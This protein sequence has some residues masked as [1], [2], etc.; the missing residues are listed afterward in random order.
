MH[1]N[2]TNQSG[3]IR[4]GVTEE[5]N[6]D[7][8]KYSDHMDVLM[9]LTSHLALTRKKSRTPSYLAKDLG[10]TKSEVETVLDGFSGIF[11]RSKN[12]TKEGNEHFYTLHY[13]FA[14]RSQATDDD[15]K[16]IGQP[17]SDSQLSSLV[18]FITMMQNS[19]RERHSILVASI[20]PILS[21]VIAASAALIVALSN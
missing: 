7:K 5:Y 18:N 4:L 19:E 8:L 10:V 17:L 15:D 21:S 9:A 14:L 2:R 3:P 13:R 20:V 16:D 11:R 1:L 6:M 12:K